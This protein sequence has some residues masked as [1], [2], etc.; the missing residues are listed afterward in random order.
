MPN[1]YQDTRVY[2]NK[3]QI[4]EKKIEERGLTSLTHHG[5]F[6]INSI[7]LKEIGKINKI[8]HP[9]SASDKLYK[10]AHTYYGDSSYWWV[11]AW[12]NKKPMDS[13]YKIG[14]IVYLP[15]PLEEALYF[16]T[17]EDNL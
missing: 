9:W 12:F 17:R 2:K 8:G 7:S 13:F 5:K 10:L 14:E 4:Y 3:S 16:A 1:R 15:G 11:I 6:K